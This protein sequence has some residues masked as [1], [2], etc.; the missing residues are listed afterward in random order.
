MLLKPYQTDG[1][2]KTLRIYR[3]PIPIRDL[4]NNLDE[5]LT[6][7]PVLSFPGSD[8]IK[9]EYI[10]YEYARFNKIVFGTKVKILR[11]LSR[12]LYYND[13]RHDFS[14]Y[15]R[16]VLDLVFIDHVL[17]D[18]TD[19]DEMDSKELSQFKYIYSLYKF[20]LEAISIVKGRFKYKKHWL[21]Y[22][23]AYDEHWRIKLFPEAKTMFHG[24]NYIEMIEC[25][26][27]IL[28]HLIDKSK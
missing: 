5:Y 13:I 16:K 3:K 27:S 11:R 18:H 15:T 7:Y 8:G 19:G 25:E 10:P 22:V 12:D 4:I 28:H 1:K 21:P 20:E 24:L 14:P 9:K 2:L 26:L 17:K 6:I 23:K